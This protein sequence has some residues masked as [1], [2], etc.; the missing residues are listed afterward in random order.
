M[1]RLTR[2]DLTL[3]TTVTGRIYRLK[4][5]GG[6]TSISCPKKPDRILTANTENPDQCLV[7][8]TE[9]YLDYLGPDHQGS[10][11]P[12]CL[13]GNAKRPHPEKSIYYS[14]ALQ[15]LRSTITKAGHDG[16]KYS[17]HSNKR[18]GATTAAAIGMTEDDIREVGNWGSNQMARRY[19][20]Q[21]TPIRAT[22]NRRLHNL[23]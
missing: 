23:L 19:I 18:G 21:S 8:L 17:E 16:S 9:R 14:V 6:K 10:L 22:R 2:S 12:S 20:Q 13:P 1:S 11:Q 7:R 5:H 4:L 15:D 3:E